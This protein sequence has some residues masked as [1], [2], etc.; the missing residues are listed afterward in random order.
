MQ[1][2]QRNKMLCALFLQLNEYKN[3]IYNIHKTYYYMLTGTAD[4]NETA[5]NSEVAF[6]F[7]Y[8]EQ[9]LK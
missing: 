2:C 3:Y 7:G 6:W 5:K 1:T 9:T 8:C 4:K